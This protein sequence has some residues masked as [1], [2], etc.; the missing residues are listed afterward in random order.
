M[1]HRYVVVAVSPA[2]E[3]LDCLRIEFDLTWS[4]FDLF[5]RQDGGNT[6]GRYFSTVIV[7]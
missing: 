7:H 5:G 4:G 2:A 6:C 1:S 3:S